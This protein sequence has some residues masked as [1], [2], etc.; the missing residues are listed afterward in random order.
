MAKNKVK[1]ETRLGK[2]LLDAG[3]LT[4]DQKNRVESEYQVSQKAF[5]DILFQEVSLKTIKELLLYEVPMP[6][7]RE[8]TDEIM[9]EMVKDGVFTEAE[10]EQIVTS[11]DPG[12]ANIAE[13]LLKAG[14]ITPEQYDLSKKESEQTQ[15]PVARILIN[16]QYVTPKMVNDILKYHH[17]LIEEKLIGRLLVR[18]ELLTD[19]KYKEALEKRCRE[20]K[21]L[22]QILVE[23]YYLSPEQVRD[24]FD[25]F[26]DI[27]YFDMDEQEISTDASKLLPELFI[28]DNSVL[29]IK[30]E[31][32]TL[33]LAMLDPLNQS[34][35][36][37]VSL[38]TGCK[39]QPALAEEESLRKAIDRFFA[40]DISVVLPRALKDEAA[41]R[42]TEGEEHGKPRMEGIV[43]VTDNATTVSLVNSI[44]TTAINSR[45]T[46]IHIEPQSN[47]MRIRYRIDGMLYD[48]MTL[49]HEQELPV[50]SRLK[51]IANMDITER[52]RPQDGHM[53]FDLENNSYDI[54]A[55]TLPTHLGEKMV[56]RILDESKVLKGLFQLGFEPTDLEKIK[57]MCKKPYGMILETGPI[58]SGKTTT[59]YSC[60]N[61]I[62]VMTSNIVTIEDPIEYQLPGINQVNVDSKVNLTFATGLRAILRQDAD[63]LMV[64]EIRDA[65]TAAIA[66]RAAM[67]GHLL[68]STLHTNDAPG[69]ITTLQHLGIKPFLISSSL[70]GVIAQRLV[71]KICL[72]CRQPYAPSLEEKE[73]LELSPKDKTKLYKGT[74]CDKCFRTGYHGRTGVFEVMQIDEELKDLI[75]HEAPEA[76][77][78]EA[79][80]QKGM[81]TLKMSGIQKV[82]D[83]TTTVEET[84]RV[85]NL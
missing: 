25:R 71:R 77:I 13:T 4:E 66:V 67:T 73:L 55:A 9:E 68:F 47:Q 54:R 20:R 82:L 58:G 39:V 72:N 30:K 33:I 2:L 16:R 43:D 62:N 42:L 70:I 6:G 7:G 85:M 74:G 81:D 3:L 29:P 23:G 1:K 79:A 65:E 69:A 18:K 28:R 21:P 22:G 50:I 64:G 40:E 26:L 60:L 12:E 84:L 83:G 32:N 19:E 75:V 63:V 46:D 51:V 17:Q 53:S 44:I 14:F 31:K 45:A 8:S 10:L 41:T 48:V 37:D 57:G 76:R 56:L 59:L 27:P 35:I 5:T 15:I 49:A 24:A 38:M 80:I 34:L 61:E 52:R 36:D 11:C 78:R